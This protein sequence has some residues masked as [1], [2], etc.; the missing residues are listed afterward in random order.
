MPH[1]TKKQQ[2]VVVIVVGVFCLVSL[3]FVFVAGRGFEG[4]FLKA[5]VACIGCTAIVL[6][7]ATRK[8][9]RQY[10]WGRYRL[11]AL[12]MLAVWLG[13]DWL[14]LGDKLS[15]LLIIAAGVLWVTGQIK[16]KRMAA[17]GKRAE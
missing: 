14:H 8:L 10:S 9:G 4:A 3:A 1:L 5:I 17:I 16:R 11:V 15:K 6:L 2:F 7:V 13:R 12:L